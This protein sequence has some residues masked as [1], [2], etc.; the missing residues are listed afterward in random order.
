MPNKSVKRKF[1]KISGEF[2][3]DFLCRASDEAASVFRST[4]RYAELEQQQAIWDS[5]LETLDETAVEEYK[6]TVNAA[7]I[8][9]EQLLE[10]YSWV[11]G[12]TQT[13]EW[14]LKNDI[15][16][17]QQRDTPS[18]ITAAESRLQQICRQFI[19]RLSP[20]H[21]K[22]CERY[23]QF[24]KKSIDIGSAYCIRHGMEFASVLLKRTGLTI[25]GN[26]SE[27]VEIHIM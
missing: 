24:R 10:D 26:G 13:I 3:N 14:H 5:V 23:L 20:E 8:H 7:F 16:P 18:T 22:I 25:G 11:L 15:T 2:F 4:P 17:S 9:Y 27:D 1:E 12:L 19:E 6:N 21:R